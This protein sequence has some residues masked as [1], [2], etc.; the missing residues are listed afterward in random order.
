MSDRPGRASD[1]F[2]L[3]FPDGMRDRLKEAAR[4]SGRSLNAEIIFR[5]DA[6]FIPP[7]EIKAQLDEL[8][9]II[10][11]TQERMSVLEAAQAARDSRQTQRGLKP[12]P[13]STSE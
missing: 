3:R 10:S 11:R 1:Q 5:L 8:T 6:S 2:N 9:R 13:D 12:R 4:E 7:K